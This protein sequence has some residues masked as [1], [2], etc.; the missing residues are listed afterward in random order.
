MLKIF[1]N[2][3]SKESSEGHL[4]V[5]LLFND[6]IFCLTHD[7]LSSQILKVKSIPH[8]HTP[9]TSTQGPILLSPCEVSKWR[10]CVEVTDFGGLNRSGPCV[11]LT[12]RIE[13]L[14]WRM[15]WSEGNPK[16]KYFRVESCW[17]CR[18]E[19]MFCSLAI[20]INIFQNSRQG[21]VG[22]I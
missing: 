9:V 22:L 21:S 18:N 7:I 3:Y 6:Y 12:C 2:P 19:V 10:I 4:F 1:L 13:V 14:K 15:C 11:E 16:I 17:V 5:I 8:F 20:N